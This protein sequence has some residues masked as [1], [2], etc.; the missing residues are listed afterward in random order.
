MFYLNS[1]NVESRNGLEAI[2]FALMNTRAFLNKD[3]SQLILIQFKVT[4]QGVTL[5]DLN[6]KKFQKQHFPTNTVIYCAVDEK[7]T[8]PV[9]M[10]KIAHPR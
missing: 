8:W 3:S 1:V 4:A 10:E 2:S 9:K 5:S 6:K 7:L